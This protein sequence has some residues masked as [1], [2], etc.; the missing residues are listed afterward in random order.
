MPSKSPSPGRREFVK[1]TAA[2]AGGLLVSSRLASA[3][4]LGANDR[5]RIGVIGTGGRARYLMSLLKSLKGADLVAVCDA[6]E[7]RALDAARIVGS[8]TVVGPADYRRLLDDKEIDAVV[9]GAPD[10]WHRTMLLDSVA[11][12]KDVY[13]EKP[14]SHSLDEGVEMVRAVEASPQVVQTGTQQRSWDHWILGKQIVDS[15]RLGQIT[16]VHTYWYQRMGLGG[17]DAVDQGRLDWKRWLGTAPEAPFDPERFYRWRHFKDYGG[18]VLTDLLT[19]WIDVVHWY[20]G[21]AEPRTAVT[22]G[23]NYRIKTFE[24][25]DTVTAS[26]EYPKAFM[27][28]HTGTY[29]SSI[30]D[31]GLEFRGDEATL[32]IDRERLLLFTEDSRKPG[33]GNTPEP[34]IVARSEGDGTVA[35]L[36]NW[37]DCIRSRKTPNAPIRVGHEAVRAAH[38]AN[39]SLLRGIRVGW[40]AGAG[41]IEGD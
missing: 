40:N 22:T 21:V 18:G 31:G 36:Q 5:I 19:H 32:K 4:V 30:D 15:G 38:I 37:L 25:P 1:T 29:S 26:F 35:H 27:V 10:H 28:T 20:M 14:I 17:F 11:A 7:P 34:E 2:A 23:G 16:F 39:A 3:R 9:I 33:A 8:G 12:G 41:R 6:Y 24:W 13:V